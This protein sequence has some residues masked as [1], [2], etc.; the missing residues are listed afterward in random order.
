MLIL[1]LALAVFTL[2]S[3]DNTTDPEIYNLTVS[4]SI[5][6]VTPIYFESSEID[7]LQSYVFS[8]SEVNGYTFEYWLL[9][10]PNEELSTQLSFVYA[11]TSDSTIIAI[12]QS[13]TADVEY[14][15]IATSNVGSKTIQEYLKSGKTIDDL[16]PEIEKI[17]L[18][19]FRPELLNRFTSKIIFKSLS[20]EDTKAI[21]RLQL[22][23]LGQRLEN[24]QGVE[25]TFT[26][27][28]VE[29]IARHGYSPT[30]GA[31]FLQRLIEKK[32][33]NFLAEKI[34]KGEVKRG[35]KLCFD[36]SDMA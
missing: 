26:E 31:R 8:T 6:G 32:V 34:L 24:A 20:I 35:E 18:E 27:E 9:E 19:N 17:L 13:D 30:Y 14:N 33:E 7:G 5:E 23:K 3:C 15:I 29:K 4:S 25:L 2:S 1:T 12:Y 11:P 28:A 22:R 21:T 16:Q 36:A 10:G